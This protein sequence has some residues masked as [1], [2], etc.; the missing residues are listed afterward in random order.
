LNGNETS[1]DDVHGELALHRDGACL[2]ED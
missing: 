1:F 2:M